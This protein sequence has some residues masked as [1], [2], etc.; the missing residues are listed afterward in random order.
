MRTSTR[1]S[2]TDAGCSRRLPSCA[3][4]AAAR[5]ARPRRDGASPPRESGAGDNARRA[6]RQRGTVLWFQPW[7]ST[8]EF[9]YPSRAVTPSTQLAVRMP[10]IASSRCRY[11]DDVAS[12]AWG[13]LNSLVAFHTGS[14]RPRSTASSSPRAATFLC[15]CRIR[16]SYWEGDLVEFRVLDFKGR[17]KA[18]RRQNQR[19]A[20][21]QA[22]RTCTR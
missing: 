10:S 8:S 18:R 7:K 22:V 1:C 13:V 14:R 17:P 4:G 11:G 2:R 15:I 12:M 16:K 3:R 20:S 19:A 9:D 21:C 5:G 6:P